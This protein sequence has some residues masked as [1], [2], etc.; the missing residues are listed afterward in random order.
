MKRFQVA[1]PILSLI[2][3]SMRKHR[4]DPQLNNNVPWIRELFELVIYS[5][6]PDNLTIAHKCAYILNLK[7]IY[8]KGRFVL[9]KQV[10]AN[11][12]ICV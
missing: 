5:V 11:I 7:S 8:K 9:L 10:N 3:R 12:E 1:G 4:K 2:I 6:K